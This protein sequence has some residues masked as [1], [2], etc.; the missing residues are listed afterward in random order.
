MVHDAGASVARN[1]SGSALTSFT[2]A[3]SS[4]VLADRLNALAD[5][6]LASRSDDPPHA[7]KAIYSLTDKGI[8]L[9]PILVQM[10]AWTQRHYPHTRRAEAARL[11]QAPSAAIKKL[12][13]SLRRKSVV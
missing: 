4:N 12:Q 5:N 8:E 7:Q 9:L 13:A 3:I 11:V 1:R 2:R 10:S 6:G